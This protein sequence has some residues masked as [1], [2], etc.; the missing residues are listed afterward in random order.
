MFKGIRA[1]ALAVLAAS[2]AMLVA[3]AVA[4]I[5]D[6]KAIQVVDAKGKVVG[7]LLGTDVLL[8][9]E[10]KQAIVSLQ[11]VGEAGI[12]WVQY[13]GDPVLFSSVDCSGPAAFVT[14]VSTNFLG[15]AP[16][17]VTVSASGQADLFQGFDDVDVQLYDLAID[18]SAM[19]KLPLHL[20]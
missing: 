18:L 5:A 16:T 4:G 9:I 7:R 6:L 1:M 8:S 14:L 12:E 3:P 13:V 19:F 15:T 20:K 11:S 17:V 10:D 2:G